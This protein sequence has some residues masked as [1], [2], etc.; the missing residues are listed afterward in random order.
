MDFYDVDG[1]ISKIGIFEG[2]EDKL[3]YPSD[4]DFTKKKVI[5]TFPLVT[6]NE[7]L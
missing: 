6:L 2:F 3:I 1:F 5:H 4:Y 7:K